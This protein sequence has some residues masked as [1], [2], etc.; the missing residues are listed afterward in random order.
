MAL[1]PR[2]EDQIVDTGVLHLFAIEPGHQV[3]TRRVRDLVMTQMGSSGADLFRASAE[4][5]FP[6]PRP[7]VA[8]AARVG[9]D[10]G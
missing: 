8:S 5:P 4:I 1:G 2:V 6:S 7:T 9:M 10:I 3:H